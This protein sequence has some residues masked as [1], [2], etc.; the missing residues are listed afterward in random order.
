MAKTAGYLATVSVS[1]VAGGA[2]SYDVVNG[3][4]SVNYDLGR[5]EL[6]TSQ[7]GEDAASAMVGRKEFSG[8]ASGK[9]DPADTGQTAV[10]TA[11]LGGAEFW[12]KV[13][14]NGVAGFKCRVLVKCKVSAGV[15]DA[16]KFE[17]SWRQIAAPV[18][19]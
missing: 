1:A 9:Y 13:L 16:A 4:D 19:V 6:D 8:S 7:F 3:M 18:A 10:I 14:P 17:F 15:G 12:V 11:T 5:E 2:G